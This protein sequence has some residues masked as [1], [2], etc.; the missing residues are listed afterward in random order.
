MRVR[1]AVAGC[2]I[3]CLQHIKIISELAGL[4]Y[5]DGGIAS[6]TCIRYFTFGERLLAD[7]K[8]KS[9]LYFVGYAPLTLSLRGLILTGPDNA[10]E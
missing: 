6:K 9:L 3:K 10:V 5:T 7:D 4:L 1:T 2:L 8:F